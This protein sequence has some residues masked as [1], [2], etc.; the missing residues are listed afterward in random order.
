MVLKLSNKVN[1][2][3]QKYL[4]I[5]FTRPHSEGTVKIS[6]ERNTLIDQTIDLPKHAKAYN[7]RIIGVAF[8]KATMIFQEIAQRKCNV[9][10]TTPITQTVDWTAYDDFRA[11]VLKASV[12]KLYAIANEIKNTGDDCTFNPEDA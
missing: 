2:I 5:T 8:D 4:E 10:V 11:E 9:N 6:L 1:P 7:G 12:D 3:T